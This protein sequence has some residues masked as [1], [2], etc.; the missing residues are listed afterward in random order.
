MLPDE[1]AAVPRLRLPR[2]HEAALRHRRDLLGMLSDRR[3]RVEAEWSGTAFVMAHDASIEDDRCHI[4]GEGDVGEGHA[5]GSKDGA[6]W[7]I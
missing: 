2:R 1:G 6:T 7:K 4:P 3:I 5:G